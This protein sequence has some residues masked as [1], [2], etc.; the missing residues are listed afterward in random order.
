MIILNPYETT[1]GKMLNIDKV[2][3]PLSIYYTSSGKNLNYECVSN[4]NLVFITGYNKEEES[5]PMFNHPLIFEDYKGD[6]HV[7]VD[8]RKYVKTISEQPLNIFDIVK[9]KSAITNLMYNAIVISDLLEE[10]YSEYKLLFNNITTAYSF[11]I[12]YLVD[13]I[14]KLNP[15]EKLDVELASM[16]SANVMLIPDSKDKTDDYLDIITARMSQC[17]LSIPYSKKAVEQII[18]QINNYNNTFDAVVSNIKTVLPIEKANLINTQVLAGLMSN[19]W[20]GPGAEESLIISLES[21]PMWLCVVYSAISDN[22][23]KRSRLTSILDKHSRQ[24][25]AK[26]FSKNLELLMKEK[27]L[28][29]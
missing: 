23:Y 8:L 2:I 9:D 4:K 16:F 19:I 21:M 11:F 15:L 24:I 1:Y 20:F 29:N 28:T 27:I 10:N 3:K 14:V 12:S 6:K 22:T 18:A 13:I 5:L 7:A 26:E 17:K 25:N